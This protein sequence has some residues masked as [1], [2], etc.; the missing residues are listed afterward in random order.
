MECKQCEATL[1]ETDRF[2]SACGYEVSGQI[3]NES[4]NDVVR[5][6]EYRDQFDGKKL[7]DTIQIFMVLFYFA[8][9]VVGIFY[10]QQAPYHS[11]DALGLA[12]VFG[13]LLISATLMS[14]TYAVLKFKHHSD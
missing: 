2:C 4:G 6:S 11:S 13:S 3:I 14:C 8:A 5:K 7:L 12:V 10:L 9:G 1:N